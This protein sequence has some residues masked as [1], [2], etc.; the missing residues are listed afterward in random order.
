MSNNLTETYMNLR[1]V[2]IWSVLRVVRDRQV[3]EDVAQE[4]YIRVRLAA[5]Q[6]TVDH[7]EALM[8]RIARNVALDHL[9]RNGFLARVETQGIDP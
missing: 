2:L 4:T 3:A 8:H 9:R 1:Q 6:G 5:E 7:A